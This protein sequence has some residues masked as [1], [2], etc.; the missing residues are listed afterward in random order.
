MNPSRASKN[1]PRN[2]ESNFFNAKRD[3]LSHEKCVI[4]KDYFLDIGIKLVY[5]PVDFNYRN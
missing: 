4:F 3:I 2:D 5:L 1:S